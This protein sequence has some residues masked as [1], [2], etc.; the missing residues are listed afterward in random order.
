MLRVFFFQVG[1]GIYS[2]GRFGQMEFNI[3]G[4]QLPLS[5]Y[6]QSYQMKPMIFVTAWKKF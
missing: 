6:S 5:F 1:K 3:C 2:I 4:F